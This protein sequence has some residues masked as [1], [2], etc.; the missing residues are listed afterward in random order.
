MEEKKISFGFSKTAKKTPLQAGPAASISQNRNESKQFIK[1][2]EGNTI[3]TVGPVEEPAGPLV[4]PLRVQDKITIPDRLAQVQSIK[5]EK[6]ERLSQKQK[7]ETTV[8][9]N[10]TEVAPAPPNETLDQRA[11]REIVE[12]TKQTADSANE[13]TNFV[14]PL[15]P[16]ELPLDG[17]RESTLDDYETIPI[18]SFGMAM[19][20]GMGLKEDP[21]KE[22]E[23]GAPPDVGPVMRP[24]GLGLGADRSKLSKALVTPLVPAGPGEVLIMKIG[25]QVKAV[26]GKHQDRYGTVESI[27]EETSRVMVKFT[28]GG[29]KDWI[30]EY[31][32]MLVSKEEYNQYAKVLNAT[33]YEEL[34][35]RDKFDKKRLDSPDTNRKNS[36]KDSQRFGPSRSPPRE[37]VSSSRGRNR[38][39]SV[40]SEESPSDSEDDERERRKRKHKKAS[41]SSATYVRTSS[42]SKKKSHKY[43]QRSNNHRRHGSDSE[44][45]DR[46]HKKKTKK[47]KKPR[48]RSRSRR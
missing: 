20:R 7:P 22:D 35:N 26:V 5:Q 6:Q 38:T 41:S 4:I 44:S 36:Q 34:K 12:A 33:K 31:M 29:I 48:S 17:A 15:L 47:S 23:K 16:E 1:C 46:R 11:A 8:V 28:L 14:V 30:N 27:D 10:T 13:K 25:A 40:S 19:L 43:K 21:K 18:Q 3:K 2:V 39:S 42:G 45:D 9:K 37:R 24:K 32:I